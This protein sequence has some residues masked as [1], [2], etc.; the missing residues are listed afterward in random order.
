MW[1]QFMFVAPHGFVISGGNSLT[2]RPGMDI[3]W[4]LP[5]LSMSFSLGFHGFER[6]KGRGFAIKCGAMGEM[7]RVPRDLLI[8][9]VEILFVTS[10][11]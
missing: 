9:G 2:P 10:I 5:Q 3:E 11:C 4:S 8:Q 1:L 6:T 7:T